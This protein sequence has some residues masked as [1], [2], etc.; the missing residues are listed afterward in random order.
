MTSRPRHPR[1]GG[2][3]RP[4][5]W[6]VALLVASAAFLAVALA[7]LLSLP[8]HPRLGAA[9][10]L[11]EGRQTGLPPAHAAAVR[12]ALAPYPKGVA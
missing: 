7:L 11:P 4:V 5:L 3:P 1:T 2:S 12:G 9:A 8:V 6:A 10:V